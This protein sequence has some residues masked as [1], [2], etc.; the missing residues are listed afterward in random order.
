MKKR[1][2]MIITVLVALSLCAAL[3][4]TG[5]SAAER[6]IVFVEKGDY[7]YGVP[8][9][10]TVDEFRS[11]YTG[12]TY[13]LLD[14]EGGTLRGTAIVYTGCKLR[15]EVGVGEVKELTIIIRGDTSGDG[16]ITSTDYLKIKAYLR[17]KGS[18]EGDLLLA[19]DIDGNGD[20]TTVDYI[21]VKAYFFGNYDIYNNVPIMPDS[22][23][24]TSVPVDSDESWTSGWQ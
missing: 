22:S 17:G 11:E 9:G 14:K 5:S 10:W 18:L 24:D 15:Y 19:A 16:R 6:K 1:F 4:C 13:S 21:N 23:E 7:L 20:V 3:L 12:R 2:S 8:D